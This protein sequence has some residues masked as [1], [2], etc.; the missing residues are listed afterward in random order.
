M[1]R[2]FI[3]ENSNNNAYNSNGIV[4]ALRKNGNFW[5]KHSLFDYAVVVDDIKQS[6]NL[7]S[8][9]YDFAHDK[10]SDLFEKKAILK[11]VKKTKLSKKYDTELSNKRS[12]KRN[13]RN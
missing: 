7:K 10:L 12:K 9:P 4:K 6:F 1:E 11:F 3:V 2:K 5:I 8:E 13:N